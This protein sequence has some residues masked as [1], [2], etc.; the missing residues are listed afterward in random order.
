[1]ASVGESGK[2][3]YAM[4]KGALLAGMRSLAVEYAP[5]GIRVNAVTPG[6]V[7]TPMNA[8]LPHMADPEARARARGASPARTG[9]PGGCGPGLHLP[10]ERRRPVG[11]RLEPHRG[12]GIY[13]HVT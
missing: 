3:L 12:R 9:H 4:T 6:A 8:R 11:D 2:S 7:L 13:R 1:M 5:R 10:A